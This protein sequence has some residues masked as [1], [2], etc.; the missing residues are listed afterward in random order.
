MQSFFQS[1]I[2]PRNI[3]QTHIRLIPKIHG[4]KRVADY[5]PIALCN[6][7]YKIISKI[8]TLRLQSE[9]SAIIFENQSAFVPGRVILDNVMITH[10]VLHFLKNSKAKKHCSMAVKMDMIKAY[11]RIEWD[12]IRLVLQRL[13]FHQRWINLIIQ[14]VTTVS[15]SYLINRTSQGSLTLQ[16]G[17][18]QGD[19]LS[20]T[21]SSFVVKYSLAYAKGT[22][23]MEV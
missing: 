7:Y 6:V 13:G 21:Y 2:M 20:H 15:Y 11:D 17:I 22:N 5:R 3:N 16:R 14:C 18:R 8:L 23:L 12:F 4:P 19:P 10:E 9:L 1:S